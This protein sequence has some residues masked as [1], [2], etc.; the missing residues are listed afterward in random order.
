MSRIRAGIRREEMVEHMGISAGTLGKW[1]RDETEPKL[2]QT[3]RWASITHVPIEWVAYGHRSLD[4]GPSVERPSATDADLH[5][6]ADK[7]ADELIALHQPTWATPAA[8]A[9]GTKPTGCGICFPH[10]GSWP[11]LSRMAADDLRRVVDR[12]VP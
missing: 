11:C 3:V 2:S 10:D 5:I 1:E 12:Q 4:P 8:Q 9:R 6:A 7:A